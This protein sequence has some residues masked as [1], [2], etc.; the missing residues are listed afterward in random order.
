M[1]TNVPVFAL[2]SNLHEWTAFIK[3]FVN[4]QKKRRGSALKDT[5]VAF[6]MGLDN[7]AAT[8]LKGGQPFFYFKAVDTGRKAFSRGGRKALA[9]TTTSP[10]I[11]LS[12]G[13]KQAKGYKIIAKGGG[14]VQS[15]MP[16]A[17]QARYDAWALASRD[18]RDVLP[19]NNPTSR[20][21]PIVA[22]RFTRRQLKGKLKL[23]SA[24]K[25]FTLSGGVNRAAG[26]QAKIAG[27]TVPQSKDVPIL[28]TGT[29]PVPLLPTNNSQVQLERSA[30]SRQL[31]RKI[32]NRSKIDPATIIN[33]A[34][35]AAGRAQAS[36]FNS[37]LARQQSGRALNLGAFA[38]LNTQ[39]IGPQQISPSDPNWS[40]LA[41]LPNWGIVGAIFAGIAKEQVGSF[42]R[43]SPSRK[44]SHRFK[45][46]YTNG[47][48]E[49]LSP[50]S[51]GQIRG[52]FVLV[53]D[54]GFESFLAKLGVS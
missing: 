38:A 53:R 13:V 39:G 40:R 37:A 2:V 7:W 20:A 33:A 41:R 34:R 1:P 24:A 43:F 6:G 14:E 21:N 19:K 10:D 27:G 17:V 50:V 54:A 35:L 44:T 12:F 30:G 26:F 52:G 22:P 31:I 45:L 49:A 23:N 32:V 36:R 48:L 9:F 5:S 47:N 25:N 51:G 16:G 4:E 28:K 15:Q 46:I 8:H 3:T 29:A 18:D 42:I 11:I